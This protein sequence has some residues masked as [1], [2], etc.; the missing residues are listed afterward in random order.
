MQKLKE[1]W[2]E[3]DK[4]QKIL[5]L[6][7]LLI[8]ISCIVITTTQIVTQIQIKKLEGKPLLEWEKVKREGNKCKILIIVTDVEGIETIQFPD[9]DILYCNNRKTVGIDYEVENEVQYDFI[10]KTEGK[11]EK[12]ETV[13]W[14]IPRIKGEYILKDGI[15]LNKPNL[16]G[17]KSEYT[18]YLSYNG[19]NMQL[20]NWINDEE[21]ENWYNYAESKWANIYVETGGIDVYYVW[22]PRYCFKLD[23]EN[24][25]SDVKF[26][27]VYNN[28]K[29][30]EGN[31]IS[32]EQLEQEGYQIPEAFTFNETEIPGYW[33]MK[34]TS[35]EHIIPSTINYDMVVEKGLITIKN[36]KIN[37]TITAGNP[38]KRYTVAVNGKIVETIEREEELSNISSQI[39]E[40][41]TIDNSEKTINITGLNEGGE[42]VGSMTKKYSPAVVNEP[43]LS[44]F[45]QDTT[46]YV[47]YD[48]NGNEHSTIPI[49]QPAPKEWYEYGY[50]EWANI[51]TRNNG[52][53]TYYTWIPRYEFT[54]DQTNQRSNV[55]FLEG[56][57]GAESGYQVPEAFTFN[58]QE[59]TGY[60]AMKYTAR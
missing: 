9:G 42:T 2:K 56:T 14:E 34:Y 49:S 35:G 54:L 1:W 30:V 60:W 23:Q 8:I 10:I 25:R 47:T 44:G 7:L 5:L 26:I 12:T 13:Y 28:Y 53:E 57:A 51:V 27:D 58:G 33:G 21:P 46:F 41:E 32:W 39:I 20:E 22:I 11:E 31:V 4:K 52:L 36:I 43:E 40:L 6:I 45:N 24:Q 17:Y 55:K 50:G 38:I 15:Y 29:D 16:T 59:L 19:Q 18:R 37:E 3:I 48:E